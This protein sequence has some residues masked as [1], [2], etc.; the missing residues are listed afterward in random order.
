VEET[1]VKEVAVLLL[2]AG[3][4]AAVFAQEQSPEEITRTILKTQRISVQWQDGEFK[5][6][7]SGDLG[8]ISSMS[9]SLSDDEQTVESVIFEIESF[10]FNAVHERVVIVIDPEAGKKPVPMFSASGNLDKVLKAI[11]E[12]LKLAYTVKKDG[13]IFVSTKERIAKMEGKTPE[14]PELDVGEIFLLVKDGSKLKGKVK[15]EKW[16]LKAAYGLLSIPTAEIKRIRFPREAKEGEE[17]LKEDEVATVRFT[18]TGNLEIDKLE[19]ET[20]YGKLTVSKSDIA[21][22]LFPRL[23]VAKE[24]QT[25]PTDEQELAASKLLADAKAFDQTNPYD[26]KEKIAEKYKE[27]IEKYP[28]TKAAKEAKEKYEEIMQRRK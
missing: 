26:P 6:T 22:I 14:V 20:P 8:M 12:P 19:V 17:A 25:K 18:A 4:A 28:D 1:G 2:I 13:T 3:I 16:N 5:I 7:L 11:L 10:V 15:L 21:E 9:G 24:A 23:S 27:V